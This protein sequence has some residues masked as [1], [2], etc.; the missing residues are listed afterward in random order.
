MARSRKKTPIRGVADASDK[1]DKSR[2]NRRER[3]VVKTYIAT[4]KGVDA[5]P[6]KRELSDVWTFAKDGKGRYERT[7]GKI[8]RK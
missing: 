4:D 7:D 8:L 2:A 5:L 3:R 6:Q 1:A